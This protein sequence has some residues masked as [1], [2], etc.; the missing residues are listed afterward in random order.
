GLG[1][2]YAATGQTAKALAELRNVYFNMPTS[3][4]AASALPWLHKLGGAATPASLS[5]RWTRADLLGKGKR[6]SDAAAEYHDLLDEVSPAERSSVQL[7][8]AGALQKSGRTSDAKRILNSLPES[9]PEVAGQ[10]LF[11]LGEVARATDDNDGFLRLQA[12][13]RQIDPAS[14]W[15]EQSL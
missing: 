13:L 11:L 9:I 2:A 10:R 15:L 14:P 6:Y 8:L 12:Q 1:R 7:A 5:D 4:E 3:P